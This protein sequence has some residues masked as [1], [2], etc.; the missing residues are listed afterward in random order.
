MPTYLAPTA[1]LPDGW[2]D[3]VRLEVDEAGTLVQVEARGRGE[4]ATPLAGPVLPGVPNV[5]SHAFQ[6]GL[7]GLAEAASSP[8]DSFWTWRDV[9]YR[10]VEQVGPEEQEAL[11]L[12]LYVEMLEAGYTSV[13]EF[14]YLHGRPGGGAY[15]DPAE[16]ARRVV[17]AARRAGIGITLLPVLYTRGGFDDEPLEG[18]QQRFAPPGGDFMPLL[19]TLLDAGEDPGVRIGFAPHSLRAVPGQRLIEA[20]EAARALDPGMPIHVHAAEQEGEVESCLADR[21]A[22][23]VEWLLAE[24]AAGAGWCLIHCTHVTPE[25]T[26]ALARSAAVAGLCPTTEANLGDGIFPLDA[27]LSHGGGFAVGSDSHVSVSPAEELRWLEYGQRL[28][29]RERNVA[30]RYHRSGPETTTG[31]APPDGASRSTGEVLY[32]GALDG[33]RAALGRGIGA[34]EPGLRA[35]WIVLDPGHPGVAARP[36]ERILDGWL[37]SGSPSPVRDV[38]VGGRWVVEEGRHPLRDEAR[39]SFVRTLRRLA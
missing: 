2:A 11:A 32:R 7:V 5:H 1:L 18:A 3:D 23:P 15:E 35:D 20:V 21:G 12:H 10:F 33:G 31:E 22:R 30:A 14:H 39:E 26:E 25:E 34:L 13:G 37:F 28:R 17:S 9:M 29:L 19:E 16:M 4:G 24:T 27:Y 36:R 6:R 38:M 8:D